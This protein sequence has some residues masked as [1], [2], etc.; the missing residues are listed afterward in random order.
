M[1]KI[2]IQQFI[3][4]LLPNEKKYVNNSL[5]G[6][7][8]LFQIH[9][10]DGSSF[11]ITIEKP[12]HKTYRIYDLKNEINKQTNIIIKNIRLYING[13]EEEIH[14]NELLKTLFFSNKKNL[15][16]I[17]T[18]P[19]LWVQTETD[20]DVFNYSENNINNNFFKLYKESSIDK[21]RFNGNS[22]KR[23]CNNYYEHVGVL[24]G[25]V[26]NSKRHYMEIKLNYKPHYNYD[27]FGVHLINSKLSCIN[28]K[29]YF[30]GMNNAILYKLIESE[31]CNITKV[32]I[33][34][35]IDLDKR[36]LAYYLR[37]PSNGIDILQEKFIQIGT[38]Q[39]YRIYEPCIRIIY[40]N[41]N[42]KITIIENAQFPL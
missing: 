20:S 22:V 25:N 8:L 3:T 6:H 35:L 37:I 7:I 26:L 4:N 28:K 31:N 13:I 11:P 27:F 41:L 2:K 39:M 10:F 19:N 9:T 16:M 5:T 36:C 29:L 23:I 1:R 17:K 18:I 32:H 38:T 34:F 33:G 21:C 14:N 30:S 40:L 42:D 12:G 15:F 24:Y